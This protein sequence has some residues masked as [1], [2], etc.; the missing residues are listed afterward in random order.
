MNTSVAAAPKTMTYGNV[1]VTE[2]MGRNTING[3]V[4]GPTTGGGM[5]VQAANFEEAVAAA[6]QVKN[7][8][9]P[10]L[11]AAVQAGDGVVELRTVQMSEDAAHLFGSRSY[12]G[13]KFTD[14]AE[15]VLGIFD[16][17]HAVPAT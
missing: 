17:A 1:A 14:A 6:R 2:F 13:A 16:W 5:T 10:G 15:G 7:C 3:T 8:A 9:D 12:G 11:R 4:T